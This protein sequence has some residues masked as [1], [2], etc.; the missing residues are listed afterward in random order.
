MPS[1]NDRFL[2]SA[3]TTLAVIAL[4]YLGRTILVP[5]CYGFLIAM[6]LYPLVVRLERLGLPRWSAIGSG[7]L[8][9]A[10]LFAGLAWILIGQVD[11]FLTRLPEL[12]GRSGTGFEVLWQ[13]V[14]S[15]VE[16]VSTDP[17]DTWYAR[18]LQAFPAR[19][20]PYLDH[21]VEPLF[22]MVFD[23]FIIP[24][25]AALILFDR[26]H[27][28][29]VLTAW[30]DPTWAPRLPALLQKAVTNY[31]RFILGMAQVYLIVGALNSLGFLALGVPNAVLFGS[32]TAVATMI[33]YV[34]IIL[35]SLLPI[36]LAYTS[37]GTWWMP[38]GVIAVLAVVQY[39][40][41]NL[42]FP[43]IVGGKLGLNTMVSLLV[44]FAGGLIWGIAGMI[45]FLPLVSVLKLVSEEVPR[46]AP[47]RKLLGMAKETQRTS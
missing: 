11:R 4:L 42:I 34:G 3:L 5:L 6:V 29:A 38:V 12:T 24:V 22:G 25:F 36:T 32:L 31:A 41:A 39:L 45:L 10:I 8:L 44:I 35:A 20:A 43:R 46:W 33:P 1:V 7:L 26:R 13:W 19:L 18:V 30:I 2:R 28:V 21:L 37:T 47:L 9:I 40:E 17:G 23:L 27:W 14:Q 16:R 15:E